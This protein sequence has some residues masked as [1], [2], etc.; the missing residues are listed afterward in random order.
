[1][2]VASRR[3]RAGGS[4]WTKGVPHEFPAARLTI[5]SVEPKPSKARL[6]CRSDA[7]PAK[8]RR[9]ARGAAL[10]PTGTRETTLAQRRGSE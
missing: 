9:N 8:A 1:M 6:I 7:A 2:T 4:G 3:G 5:F 10:R